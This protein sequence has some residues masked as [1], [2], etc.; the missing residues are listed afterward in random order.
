V[1]SPADTHAI[2]VKMAPSAGAMPCQ[3]ALFGLQTSSGKVNI[4][5]LKPPPAAVHYP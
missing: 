4:Q 2:S 5:Q 3:S 1:I